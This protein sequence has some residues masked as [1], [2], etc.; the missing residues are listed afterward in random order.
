MKSAEVYF[1][2]WNLLRSD[3]DSSQGFESPRL[4]SFAPGGGGGRRCDFPQ[5][6]QWKCLTSRGARRSVLS[7]SELFNKASHAQLFRRNTSHPV[8]AGEDHNWN[9]A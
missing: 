1:L 5:T 6:G 9:A 7:S 2:Q 8:D 3:K 4:Q